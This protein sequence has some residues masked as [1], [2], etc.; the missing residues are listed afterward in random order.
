[1][2]AEHLDERTSTRILYWNIEAEKPEGELAVEYGRAAWKKDYDDPAH[3]DKM[4]LGKAWGLG[5][6]PW[7]TL[8]MNVP[9]R[10]GG[11]DIPAGQ[12]YLGLYRSAG[13]GT[14]SLKFLDPAKVPQGRL[15]GLE[16]NEAAVEATIPINLEESG[17]VNEL[18]TITLCHQ[19]ESLS[20]VTLKVMW[21]RLQLS[22]LLQCQRDKTD[23]QF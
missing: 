7:T 1:M 2:H 15:D 9:L 20:N 16:I 10:I 3:F 4:T 19:R 21:G 23:T 13:G 17:Q 6:D 11:K 12:Y 18:L 14:W 5:E 22:T 8:D